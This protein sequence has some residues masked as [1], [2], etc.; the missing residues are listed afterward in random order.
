[1]ETGPFFSIGRVLFCLG[2]A[3]ATVGA[4]SLVPE[5]EVRFGRDIRPLLSNHCFQC[6]GPDPLARQEDLRLDIREEAIAD[7]GGYAAIVPGDA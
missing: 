5:E 2:L 6:H 1:M 3:G 7:R 4:V